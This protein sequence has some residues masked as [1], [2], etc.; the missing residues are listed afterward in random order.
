MGRSKPH[1]RIRPLL[2]DSL[3]PRR[4]FSSV[5]TKLADVNQTTSYLDADSFTPVGTS[6]FFTAAAFHG[7]GAELWITDGTTAG[8]RRVKDINPGVNSS[9]PTNLFAVGNTLYFSADDGV[10]GAEL[11]KSGGTEAGTVLVKDINPGTTASS[12]GTVPGSTVLGTGN[13]PAM[14]DN[15]G[16]LFFVGTDASGTSLFKSDGTAAGT[17]RWSSANY[18][19]AARSPLAAIGGNVYFGAAASS[20]SN[21]TLYRTVGGAGAPALITLRAFNSSV[22]PANL[23]VMGGK[24][25]FSAAQSSSTKSDLYVT[26]GSTAGTT[27]VASIG[28]DTYASPTTFRASGPLIYFV[29]SVATSGKTELW[30]S[31]GTTAGTYALSTT[32]SLDKSFNRFVPWGTT[33]VFFTASNKLYRSDGTVATTTVVG[34]LPTGAI[35]NSVVGGGGRFYALVEKA[36][37]YDALYSTDGSALTL[38]QDLNTHFFW[39][40]GLLNRT[41]TNTPDLLFTYAIGAA[42]GDLWRSGGTAAT[43]VRVGTTFAANPSGTVN[44]AASMRD[45][46]SGLYDFQA[47]VPYGTTSVLFTADDGVNGQELWISTPSTG[48]TKL[49]ADANPGAGSSFPS[50]IAVDSASGNVYFSAFNEATGYELFRATAAG[51]VSLVADLAAGSTNGYPESLRIV[52]TT[53]YFQATTGSG[54]RYLYAYNLT[55]GGAPVQVTDGGSPLI[56]T[57]LVMLISGTTAVVTAST[58]GNSGTY[59]LYRIASG[60]APTVIAN[61]VSMERAGWGDK[62]T[63]TTGGFVYFVGYDATHGSEL[64]RTDG[65]AANSGLVKDIVAGTSDAQIN[66][67]TTFGGRVYFST[68]ADGINQTLWTSDGTS[69]GTTAYAP[70]AGFTNVASIIAEANAMDFIAKSPGGVSGVY[71]LPFGTGNSTPV[72]RVAATTAMQP[73]LLYVPSASSASVFFLSLD[74][75]QLYKTYTLNRLNTASPGGFD[76]VKQLWVLNIYDVTM[77]STW[78]LGH[79]AF[80]SV[81]G[82][83]FFPAYSATTGTEPYSYPLTALNTHTTGDAYL[84]F[85]KNGTRDSGEPAAVGASV[86][87]DLDEDGLF[88]SDEPAT[89]TDASGNYDFAGLDVGT[90]KIR[91]VASGGIVQSEP[92]GASAVI[93][94]L[95]PGAMTAAGTG[96]IGIIDNVPPAVTSIT[97][98]ESNGPLAVVVTFSEAI[99]P[100]TLSVGD[101]TLGVPVGTIVP[102][103]SIAVSYDAS[104]N[105]ARFTFPGYANGL[106]P[107]GW[108]TATFKASGAADS[109]GN[110]N[111]TASTT[112]PFR[113]LC[114]DVDDNGSVDFNDLLIVAKNYNGTGKTFAQG[115]INFDA[116]GNV[117]FDDL[118]LLAKN[119]NLAL[120]TSPPAGMAA[121]LTT[122]RRRIANHLFEAN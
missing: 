20:G 94:T 97:F 102:G 45:F 108:Y 76:V 100:T 33:Q 13:V 18:T 98:D 80:A 56:P 25:Y 122:T 84:D 19:F 37:Q 83:L 59:N 30:R 65:T 116:A 22:K 17:T 46:T 78:G 106:P 62:S 48:V 57:G 82:R 55:S 31:D 90:Y 1:H 2:I 95:A 115:N 81:G 54:T 10:H 16:T 28:T 44:T 118:L 110:A 7:D 86:Y 14:V 12:P 3:E 73:T 113:V 32:L 4:L 51:S 109:F 68:Y 117:D 67:L 61:N 43:T 69:A 58:S 9:N 41:G 60:S 42:Q 114:G 52:G 53:L 103:A 112:L 63:V 23:T 38:V 93:R 111:A 72:L 120:G 36:N 50:N 35:V 47:F 15:N 11:W 104:T 49:F 39:G 87:L 99:D 24:I 89:T 21:A 101:L 29:N 96:S 92:S 70:A 26:D 5:A 74:N 8:T 105:S 71:R 85:N 40:A 107:N 91:L 66:E 79:E 75:T 119:Y 34:G 77:N 64:W 6:T 121:T 27:L 88:D